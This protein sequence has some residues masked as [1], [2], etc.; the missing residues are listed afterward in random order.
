VREGAKVGTSHG[1]DEAGTM[2]KTDERVAIYLECVYSDG[3]YID[4]L[5]LITVCYI[6]CIQNRPGVISERLFD[7]K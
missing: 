2:H 4:I 7:A 5:L 3:E 6:M 1:G